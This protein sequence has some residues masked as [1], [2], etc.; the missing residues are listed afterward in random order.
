MF[1]IIIYSPTKVANSVD[2]ESEDLDLV[3][4]L[5]GDIDDLDI[6]A[7]DPDEIHDNVIEEEDVIEEEEE[8]EVVYEEMDSCLAQAWLNG[9]DEAFDQI[10]QLIMNENI[11]IDYQHSTTKMTALIVSAARGNLMLIE[12]LIELGANLDIQDPKNN[13]NALEWAQHFKQTQAVE[14]IE[15]IVVILFL[16]TKSQIK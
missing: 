11:D 10:I 8:D 12:Q 7:A 2:I 14:Y 6:N 4:V 1:L 13:R 15:G 5:G 9:D 16:S 3:E